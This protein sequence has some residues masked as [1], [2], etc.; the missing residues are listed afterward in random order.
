MEQ[1]TCYNCKKELYG[2]NYRKHNGKSRCF[3]CHAKELEKERQKNYRG[4][5]LKALVKMTGLTHKEFC[6]EMHNIPLG[7]FRAWIANQNKPADWVFE[8]IK[9]AV[10]N[11][12]EKN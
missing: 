3:S 2:E 6:E 11:K 5:E 1:R 10:K 7:T 9:E 8:M 12:Y 4:D